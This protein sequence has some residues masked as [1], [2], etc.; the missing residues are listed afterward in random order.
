MENKPSESSS[1][2]K[3]FII[4]AIVLVVLFLIF[5]FIWQGV[6]WAFGRYVELLHVH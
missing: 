1:S 4:A 6:T 3:D 5:R 2:V